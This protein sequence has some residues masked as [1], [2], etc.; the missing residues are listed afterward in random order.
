[1]IKYERV[2][3]TP[4][5]AASWLELNSENNR[6]PKKS[7]IP[8]YARDMLTGRWN[9]DSGETIKF[10]VHGVLIDGQ[11]RL[12]AV[13][14]AGKT[15]PS[16]AID[17]DVARGLPPEAMRVIDSGSARIFADA[18]AVAGVPDRNRVGSVVRWILNWE[19]RNFMGSGRFSPTN[20]ELWDRYRAD[21]DLFVAA[22]QRGADLAH[23]SLGTAAIG[24]TAFF[25]FHQID[26][27]AAN[28][29]FDHYVS[30]AGLQSGSPILVLRNRM[31]RAR[32]ERV[33]RQ[34]RLALTIKAWNHWRAGASVNA[35]LMPKGELTN[36]NFP[37]PK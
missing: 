11:N 22:A 23:Q 6:V 15:N 26:Q 30:G 28:R 3:V 35:I 37:Q 5:L 7:K 12:Q 31:V 19:V 2:T 29:F 13:V 24:G 27:D 36:L 32:I 1:M 8:A 4:K 10:D 14:L 16:V 20:A 18:L 9:S 34:E 33:T 21:A 25:L 17:F